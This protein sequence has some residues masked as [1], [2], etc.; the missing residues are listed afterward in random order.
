M[1]TK[2][3]ES[4]FL[5]YLR[6]NMNA[7]AFANLHISLGITRRMLTMLIRNPKRFSIS[8]FTTIAEIV[9]KDYIELLLN[10]NN[11]E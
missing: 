1:K 2:E 9:G 4:Y 10:I 3:N 7:E 11:P 6:K 8:Q 5:N